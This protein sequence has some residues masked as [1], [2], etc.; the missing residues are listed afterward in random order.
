VKN[1]T[2]RNSEDPVAVP[3]PCRRQCCLDPQDICLGCGRSLA[4][5]L[6]WGG[7]SEVRRREIC[8]LA[9]DRVQ[10]AAE[11]RR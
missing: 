9:Q 1:S 2:S 6:E 3:S 10:R 4:E 5:I 8:I 7:A 11:A